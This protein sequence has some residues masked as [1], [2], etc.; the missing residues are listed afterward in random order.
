MNAL[1]TVACVIGT[2][3]EAIKMVPIIRTLKDSG[4]ARVVVIA[5]AQH[6]DLLDQMLD[7]FGIRVDHDLN[8]MRPHQSLSDLISR[9]LPAIEKILDTE[10]ADCVL[11][12]GDTTTVFASALSAFHVGIP[13][14]HVEAGLR[15]G[16]LSQPFPEEGYRQMISRIARWNFSP[17]ESAAFALRSEN[18]PESRI[19]ITGNTGIDTLLQTAE[20]LE[21][22]QS[23]DFKILLLTAHRREN[24]GAPLKEIFEAIRQVVEEQKDVQ[25]IYP[26]HPNPNVREAA[27][28]FLSGFERIHLLAPMDYF[29]F[30]EA[31]QRATL[32]LTDSGG[33]QEEAPALGKPVLI[34]RNTTER[35]EAISQGHAR[36]IGTDRE[37]VYSELTKLLTDPIQ[38]AAMSRVGYPF[39]DGHAAKRIASI[40][41]SE[42]QDD[43]N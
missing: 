19:Y 3:P 10:G 27:N 36:L 20:T 4:W 23:I 42:F 24:F 6:R 11:A 34:L 37:A 22:S 8:L 30:V 9:M 5:T 29:S 2:R 32:I 33:I 28:K 21:S 26:V 38:L 41:S 43:E 15:T 18:I 12:Q 31:M 39:G 35:P 16:N 17:T 25:L 40:L 14:G 7:R 13:F 1:R